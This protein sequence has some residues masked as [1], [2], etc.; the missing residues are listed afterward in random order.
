V[1]VASALRAGN[2]SLP[3]LAVQALRLAL[4]KTGQSYANG[5]LLFLTAGFARDAQQALTAVARAARCIQVAGGIAGGVFTDSGWVVDRPAAALMVFAGEHA[6]VGHPQAAAGTDQALLSYAGGRFPPAWREA[7][8]RRVG[9]SFAA[10]PGGSEAVAWQQGRLTAQCSV[11]LPGMQVAIGVSRGWQLLGDACRV[12]S[13]N[14]YEVLEL[15]GEAALESLQRGLPADFR[16]PLPLASLCAVLIDDD[17]AGSDRQRAFAAG[18]GQAIAILAVN[19]DRSITLAERLVPGQRLVWAMR[20]PLLVAA[21]MRRSVAELA[22][23]TQDPL[24]A[25]VFSCSGR[26][27]CFYAGEDRDLD[28]LR[29]GFPGLPLL[30]SYATGQIAPRLAGGNQLLQNAVVTALISPATRKASV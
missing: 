14:A 17:A 5:V 20:T 1:S 22:A 24:A 3:E 16:T 15:G 21:D 30:G 10:L 12:D 7:D 13:S 29:E 27:P 6:L 9:G 8:A 28:C 11:Q 25:V 18:A 19:A 23:S 2:E 4:D 26:G